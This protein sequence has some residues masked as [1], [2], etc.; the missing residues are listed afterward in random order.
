MPDREPAAGRSWTNQYGKTCSND[1]DEIRAWALRETGKP[2]QPCSNCLWNTGK[3][4]PAPP[5]VDRPTGGLGPRA[6]R[7]IDAPVEF[8]GEPVRLAVL[9]GGAADAPRLVIEGAQWLAETFFRRDPSAV[10]ANSYDTWIDKTQA[11]PG[12]RDRVIDGDVTAVNATMAARTSH[13]AWAEVISSTDW[14]WLET[15]DPRWDLFETP[16]ADVDWA[17]VAGRLAAAFDATKRPGLGFAVVTKVLHIKRPRLVP[18]MDSVVIDQIGARVSVDV[19]TW[20]AAIGQVRAVGRSN[21]N[22][23][24]AVCDH[25]REKGIA[26]RSLVRI[27]D[28][29]LWVSSPGSGLFS[30]LTGWERM[31]RPR[32]MPHL[33]R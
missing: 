3:A 18:V 23:L 24:R 8:D 30:S 17:T 33:A 25:L 5:R 32:H 11:D 4:V 20:V 14:S 19:A 1:R 27:L 6:P 26:D 10:G 7:P 13:A 22:E 21:L 9:R 12:C 31:V 15:I 28:A 16:E 2:V 29:L